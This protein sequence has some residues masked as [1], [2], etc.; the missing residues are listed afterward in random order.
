MRAIL[1]SAMMV[2]GLIG[3]FATAAHATPSASSIEDQIDKEWRSLEPTIENYD[4]VNQN[5][6]KQEATAAKLQAQIQPL[7]LEV[8]VKLAAVGKIA[9]SVYKSGSQRGLTLLLNAD[10]AATSLN[11]LGEFEQMAARQR[12]EVA[13]TV[14]LQKKYEAQAKPVNALVASLKVRAA[15]LAKDKANITKQ[16]AALDAKR[17]AAFGTSE[18]SG[19]AHPVACPQVYTGDTGSKAARF[20]CNQIGKSY[21]FDTDGPNHFDCSGLSLASWRTVG[22]TL[23]H[24]AY[25]QAHLIKLISASQLRPGDLVFYYHPISHVTVYVGNGWVVSAPHTGDIVRM[26]KMN[27]GTA[28]SAYG[29]P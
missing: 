3:G 11:I 18:D 16:I 22:V 13:G 14:A 7:A 19:S 29:R 28:P 26:K 8:Q 17:V 1:T 25:A 4:L 23:P 15:Q 2:I 10:A 20:A 5:L 9:A 6:Q 24:N 27:D 21:I 12:A